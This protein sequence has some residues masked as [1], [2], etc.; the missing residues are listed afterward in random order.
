V[1][2]DF[3]LDLLPFWLKH[4]DRYNFDSY[5]VWLHS[6]GNN[7][8]KIREAKEL[9]EKYCWT[10]RYA[11]R[12]RPFLNGQLRDTVLKRYAGELPTGDTLV[13][14]DSDEFHKI[15]YRY[16]RE[17]LEEYEVLAGSLVDCYGDT[18][19]EASPCEPLYSQYPIRGDLHEIMAKRAENGILPEKLCYPWPKTRKSKILAARCYIPVSF[20]GSHHVEMF[21]YGDG[22]PSNVSSLRGIKVHH[23]SWRASFFERSRGK[24]YLDARHLWCIG[25]YFNMSDE[26][27]KEVL[28][29][30]I[31]R[32][33]ERGAF[34]DYD[35]ER[36]V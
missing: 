25:K 9:F 18:L 11:P 6:G 29:E 21:K 4:Y 7:G 10:V 34:C 2:V 27:L 33:E 30:D 13:T 15:H 23:Y 1:G 14:A 12:D 31:R 5:T 32:Y 16:Y 17:L 19:T 22:V 24:S 8:E 36:M 26:T 20:T 28:K 3:E 35:E